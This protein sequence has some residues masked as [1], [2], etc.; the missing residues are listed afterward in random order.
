[1]NYTQTLL[2]T[3]LML[4]GY[5][6]AMAAVSAEEAAQLGDTLTPFGAEKAG[7]A[8]GTIPAWT[9]GLTEPPAD[10]QTGSGI[11]PNPWPD[12]EP[13][14]V[15]TPQN[16]AE[17]ADHLTAG[18]QALL[19]R[20]G[21]EGYVIKVY[22]TH[23]SFA[24]PD[25]Y[26]ENTIYNATHTQP[27]GDGLRLEDVHS[28]TPFPI[29]KSGI[30]VYWN[31]LL[32]WEGTHMEA[33]YKTLYK[34][35]K[36]KTVLAAEAEVAQEWPHYNR[37]KDYGTGF[38]DYYMIRVD[39]SA[40]ARRAGEKLLVIDP[41]DFTD[42]AGRRAWQYL[43]GQRRVRR[44][45]SVAFDTPNPGTAGL[46]TYD[47]AFLINGS[48]ERYDWKL[49][50]KQELYV[51]YNSY[52]FVYETPTSESLGPKFIDPDHNRWEKHRVWVIEGALKEGSRHIYHRRV[53]YVDEDSW[54]ALAT[55]LYDGQGELWRVGYNYETP[56]YE[57]PAGLALTHGHYDLQSGIY[58]VIGLVSDSA[59][60]FTNREQKPANF[61]TPQ[62]LSAGGVR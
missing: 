31:H 51:P 9:G 12:E 40:P 25:W 11:R 43:K 34:D 47:D 24:G 17:H 26:Y 50:G 52:E 13:Y 7:N 4:A 39:Y 46:A 60:V 2:V 29:P 30:E 16:M 23:R 27:A 19:Q 42:G 58:Y 59:G 62:G 35:S 33:Q 6:S 45:P 38:E 57:V 28:G 5:G 53:L 22:P 61:W 1:M 48:P 3:A 36:G 37:D 18:T 44:A 8:D 41:M 54:A 49:I 32:R 10:Y 56:S 14:L 21:D 15:I 55:D 20:Y